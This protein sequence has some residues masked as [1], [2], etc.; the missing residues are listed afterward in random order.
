MKKTTS[1]MLLMIFLSLSTVYGF[2]QS[3]EIRFLESLRGQEK[4]RTT[5]DPQLQKDAQALHQ[6]RQQRTLLLKSGNIE[7]L[8]KSL[9]ELQSRERALLLNYGLRSQNL[10]QPIVRVKA[11]DQER[12]HHFTQLKRDFHKANLAKAPQEGILKHRLDSVVMEVKSDTEWHPDQKQSF[13]F[14]YNG[15]VNS[16]QGYT[17]TE[18][19][20]NWVNT[21][22][23]TTEH[24]NQGM[25][26]DMHYE[27]WDQ[28]LGVWYTD[29]REQTS[30]DELG[31]TITMKSYY[32]YYD[33]ASNSYLLY[34]QQFTEM[35]YGADS[36]ING[37]I[38]HIWDDVLMQFVPHMKFEMLFENGREMMLAAWVWNVDSSQW[39]GE[40][41]FEYV[42]IVDTPLMDYYQYSWDTI[43]N[44]W[45]AT[46]KEVYTLGANEFGITVNYIEYQLD[47]TN[48][49][50]Q[51]NF[52][53][54]YS[55]PL[56]PGLIEQMNFG[57]LENYYWNAPETD[58][59]RIHTK[60]N[61]SFDS[62]G[63]VVLSS[64]EAWVW[65]MTQGVNHWIDIFREEWTYDT[66]G[67]M[68]EHLFQEWYFY[69]ENDSNVLNVKNKTTYS[70]N[71]DH[72]PTVITRF[73]WDFQLETWLHKNKIENTYNELGQITQIIQYAQYNE[74]SQEWI[75][76]QKYVYGYDYLG[77][78]TM[79]G[80]YYWNSEINDWRLNTK[81]EY[82]E[83][84]QGR[85][86]KDF[87][88]YWSK[89]FN[90]EVISYHEE[91][92]Y[93]ENGQVTLDLWISS[94]EYFD[95]E[96][97]YLNTY[98]YKSVYTYD[99][100]GFLSEVLSYDYENDEFVQ[101]NKTE[102]F[103]NSTHPG[104]VDYEIGYE[105]DAVNLSW[106]Q[107]RKN[108]GIYNYN[109]T[110]NQMILP[111]GQ[112]MVDAYRYF[113]YMPISSTDYMWVDSI[114]DWMENYRTLVYFTQ[115]EFS[116][117]DIPTA[118]GQMF[119]PNPVRDQLQVNLPNGVQ[120]AEL[121]LF[122]AQGRL[123]NRTQLSASQTVDL[124]HLNAGLYFYRLITDKGM[125]NGKLIKE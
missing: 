75:P 32:S 56:V 68:T 28:E 34:G 66:S 117:V 99:S 40:W 13:T 119:Y 76:E 19:G 124:A 38:A 58:E 91:Y 31:R 106:K 4:S 94:N 96:N 24:N 25:P 33:E 98:G 48:N 88:V 123:L 90:R 118:D 55:K 47:Y 65:S 14:D 112:D 17:I 41:K 109:I 103:Y 71:S 20:N 6:L 62:Q 120:Q 45:Y 83:D 69:W 11:G 101:Y 61:Y 105:W 1:L 49:S 51:P 2:K 44:N 86:L 57:L 59:W 122:D 30:Y 5:V 29:Y 82:L 115:A 12:K 50:L 84:E 81:S 52:K 53:S 73:S 60:T 15:R 79:M 104:A 35:S 10:S 18:T 110:R 54:I 125:F 85:T 92:A 108:V 26:L 95:G 97:Y 3:H 42:P 43:T 67:D 9:A 102:I 63:R 7:H 114:S 37:L 36:E 111:F 87:Y 93:N 21:Y 23:M 8:S 89:N 116:T 113:E 121:L 80:N 100:N 64:S 77:D 107:S 70:Y 74:A 27:I 78:N 72:L 22:R 16:Q 39:M 46:Y